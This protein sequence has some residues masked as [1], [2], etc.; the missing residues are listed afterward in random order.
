MFF[1]FDGI[2]GCKKS[3]KFKYTIYTVL[4]YFQNETTLKKSLQKWE[5]VQTLR[6]TK[7]N[8]ITKTLSLDNLKHFINNFF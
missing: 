5:H 1:N 4:S 7:T 8:A 6:N 2:H 3:N